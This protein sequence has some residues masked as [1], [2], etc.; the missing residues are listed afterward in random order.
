M[1]V[2]F[3][4]L[5][6]HPLDSLGATSLAT[7]LHDGR[8]RLETLAAAPVD[9]IA[10][11]HGRTNGTVAAAARDAGFRIGFSAQGL[12]VRPGDDPL[13]IPR[14]TPSYRSV[15]HFAVELVLRLLAA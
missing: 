3:H 4:T 11:P 14:I 8:D 15:G 7:A 2:G 5:R 13:L 9:T 6:H 1:T 12:P 10:Y